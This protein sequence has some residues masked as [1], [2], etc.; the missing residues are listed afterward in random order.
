MT[1]FLHL[2]SLYFFLCFSQGRHFSLH[3]KST[4]GLGSKSFRGTLLVVIIRRSS[5]AAL[6]SRLLLSI[7]ITPTCKNTR[8]IR[9]EA[10]L[11]VHA[12][13]HEEVW[14][15]LDHE[16]YLAVRPLAWIIRY[17]LLWIMKRC[18]LLYI[19]W[20]MMVNCSTSLSID[21]KL[22][23]SGTVLC[24]PWLARTKM[25]SLKSRDDQG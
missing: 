20:I 9:E 13:D 8:S 22:L 21:S 14:F 1:P 24:H 12:L 23:C 18:A 17:V 10:Y 3:H 2:V 11:A 15:T 25:I 16:M 7:L 5:S 19:L 4:A 6:E